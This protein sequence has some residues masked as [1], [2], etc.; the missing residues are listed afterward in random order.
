MKEARMTEPTHTILLAE[1]NP[2][3]RAFLAENLTA[4]G[5]E[6]LEAD[7]KEKALALLSAR[8]PEL[9][10]AD[11]NGETLSL[12]DAV[13]EADG[14]ASRIDSDTPLLIFTAR[15]EQLVRVRYLER[16][17]DDVLAK[18]YSYTELRAR[19]RA[20]LR[21]TQRSQGGRVLRL[22]KLEI[23]LPA[24]EVWIDGDRVELTAKEYEL[25]RCL[26]SEPTR[27]FTREE[28][29]RDVWG[30]PCASRSRTVDSHAARLRQKLDRPGEQ[31]LVVNVWGVGY[32]LADPPG[33]GAVK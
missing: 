9:V 27:V 28:L 12:V 5:F 14:L 15:P 17:C 33:V 7:S 8:Q 3:S 18:P 24:R 20:L 26:A 16:G 13:R 25:L 30:Y 32:R 6:V 29:L 23:D 22:G 21:R 1:E 4:D 31:R 11:V 19:L 2:A 10:L